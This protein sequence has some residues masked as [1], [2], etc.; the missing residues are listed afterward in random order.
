MINQY[1]NKERCRAVIPV[2]PNMSDEHI[3]HE[4]AYA[5]R[6]IVEKIFEKGLYNQRIYAFEITEIPPEPGELHFAKTYGVMSSPP[7]YRIEV[8]IWEI[9]K[10]RYDAL[11]L[12]AN[13]TLPKMSFWKR[14]TNKIKRVFK[15][16]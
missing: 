3:Q 5:R 6:N 8:K 14:I 7:E 12:A 10:H 13:W 9:E 4:L 16:R 15:C 1:N 11:P 2:Y